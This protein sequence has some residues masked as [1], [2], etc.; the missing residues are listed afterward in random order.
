LEKIPFIW[1]KIEGYGK[2]ISCFLAKMN[3]L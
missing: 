3:N 2:G 1:L